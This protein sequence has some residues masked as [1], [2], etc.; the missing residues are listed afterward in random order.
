VPDAEAENRGKNILETEFP[1]PGMVRCFKLKRL[2][3][4]TI[5]WD[6]HKDNWVSVTSSGL[7]IIGASYALSAI[8]FH[9]VTLLH[10]QKNSF[11]DGFREPGLVF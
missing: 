1:P 10:L 7:I 8:L 6:E 3:N 5:D 11:I 9:I 2:L 4:Q